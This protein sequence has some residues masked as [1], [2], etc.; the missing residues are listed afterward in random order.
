[1]HHCNTCHFGARNI[2]CNK[3]GFRGL[4]IE[5]P[6]SGYWHNGILVPGVPRLV[7]RKV[8]SADCSDEA[9]RINTLNPVRGRATSTKAVT[10]GFLDSLLCV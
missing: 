10:R 8:F 6:S 1:M 2:F 3:S 9:R 7:R 4:A 5:S